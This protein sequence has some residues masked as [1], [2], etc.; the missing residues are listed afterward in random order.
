[1]DRIYL[2]LGG[3]SQDKDQKI[4]E[5]KNKIF[6]DKDALKF[7]YE[8]LHAHKL[9]PDDLK[10]S[11]IALP[12]MAERRLVVLKGIQ[13]CMAPHKEIV[14]NFL[15]EQWTDTIL[16]LDSDQADI[17]NAFITKISAVAK[18]FK[19]SSDIKCNVFDMTRA[20]SSDNK[21]KALSI[22]TELIK[23]G[24]HPLQIMGGLVWFWEKSRDKLSG[25]KFKK[26]LLEL[27]ET[28]LNIKRS[29]L[30]PEHALEFCVTKLCLLRT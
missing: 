20:I 7:D 13:K 4:L 23:Q 14:L 16:I 3:D 18:V 22:L 12:A 1:M 6:P 5:I 24:D 11:L 2:F 26:G 27:Q 21:V 17:K 15:K 10:K 30:K 25:E 9:N 8:L 28:D 29:R 19:Y